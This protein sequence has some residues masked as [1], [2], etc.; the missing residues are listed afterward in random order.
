VLP[1][2][3]MSY[4]FAYMQAPPHQEN[5]SPGITSSS[6]GKGKVV[7]VTL[8][9]F[10]ALR[11][12]A[13]PCIQDSLF[14]LIEY[15]LPDPPYRV[16]APPNLEANLVSKPGTLLLNLLY[17]DA[18]R[19]LTTRLDIEEC[20]PFRNLS[21]Q[22]RAPNKPTLVTLKPEG[23]PLEF[24]YSKGYVKVIVPSV[25]DWQILELSLPSNP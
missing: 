11:S 21:V 10:Y 2:Q 19:P 7:F 14:D 16:E 5:V 22:V 13:F 20:S 23:V 3:N 12:T 25:K 9:I 1:W 17:Y 4:G 8:P 6:F 18:N 24:E 15:L